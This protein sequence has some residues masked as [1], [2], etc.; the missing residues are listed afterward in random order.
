MRVALARDGERLP[1]DVLELLAAAGLLVAPLRQAAG[2]AIVR[3]GE[4]EWILASARDVLTICM[5][6]GADAGVVGKEALLEYGADVVE[7]LDLGVA[8]RRLVCATPPP[9]DPPRRRLRLATR[10]P[11]TTAGHFAQSGRE[12]E[13][14]AVDA[15]P[16]LAVAVG[17]ADGV[18]ELEGV[19]PEGEPELVAREVV[20]DCSARLVTGRQAHTLRGARLAGLVDSLREVRGGA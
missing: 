5:L 8:R 18:V 1:A 16:W 11:R 6:G 9:S 4:V 20:A 15:A 3:T 17:V 7:L 14:M 10:F 2:P 12:V 19:I 13:P